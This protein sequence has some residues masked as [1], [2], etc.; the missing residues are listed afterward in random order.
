MD[1]TANLLA[2]LN[3]FLEQLRVKA[4]QNRNLQ[5]P[6]GGWYAAYAEDQNIQMPDWDLVPDNNTGYHA[7][8]HDGILLIKVP[9][10][11]FEFIHAGNL[12]M[13]A[14]GKYHDCK[15]SQDGDF[16]IYSFIV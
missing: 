12:R 16:A 15:L 14:N 11:D 5:E 7:W 8:V 2:A 4:N 13:Q 3:R 6:P 9:Q 1:Q 10:R